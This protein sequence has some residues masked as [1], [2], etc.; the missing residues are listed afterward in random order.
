[1]LNENREMVLNLWDKSY[2]FNMLTRMVLSERK[3]N[4]ISL[5]VNQR[6]TGN[7]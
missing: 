4:R 3:E 7:Y 1:M 6:Y 2:R 5:S